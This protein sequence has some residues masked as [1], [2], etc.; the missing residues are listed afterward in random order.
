MLLLKQW[1]T[2][3]NIDKDKSG[4]ITVD[5]LKIGLR[6]QGSVVTEQELAELVQSLDADNSGTIDYEVCCS[7]PK[8]SLF[9]SVLEVC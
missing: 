5:E 6:E 7:S 8:K 1:H 4:S 2:L 9:E 3:Q